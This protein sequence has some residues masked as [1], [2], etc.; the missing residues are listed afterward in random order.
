MRKRKRGARGQD[1]VRKRKRGARGQDRVTN[2]SLVK[3]GASIV[4][5][6]FLVTYLRVGFQHYEGAYPFSSFPM[7]STAQTNAPHT[8]VRY[9]MVGTTESGKK[10]T[11]LHAPLGTAIF[12][13]WQRRAYRSPRLRR[14]LAN[15]L[16]DHNSKLRNDA[17]EEPL[18]SLQIK[19]VRY[20]IPHPHPET[21]VRTYERVIT[22]ATR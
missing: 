3:L 19:A 5:S 20:A 6:V 17:G 16:L 13:T 2:D 8:V 4:I 22:E 15:V 1:R 18:S 12:L 21:A 14:D 9:E 7:Y 11:G 10:V